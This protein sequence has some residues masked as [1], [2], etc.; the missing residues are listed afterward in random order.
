MTTVFRYAVAI[1][2]LVCSSTA[3]AAPKKGD[4]EAAKAHYTIGNRHYARGE[5]DLAIAEF[6]IAYD[7]SEAP[8]LLY[9]LGQAHRLN[10]DCAEAASYYRQFLA[11]ATEAA[12]AT[13]KNAEAFLHQLGTCAQERTPAGGEPA[14]GAVTPPIAG[15][16][17]PGD[18][19]GGT[20]EVDDT[21][22]NWRIAGVVL[23]GVGVA[24]A[25]VGVY[26][27]ART[28]SLS[29]DAVS[30]CGADCTLEENP[31]YG[32]YE[33][34]RTGAW[35]FSTLGAVAIAGGVATYLLAPDGQSPDRAVA[36]VPVRG[37]GMVS[38]AGTF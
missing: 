14:G 31:A 37:G 11:S 33:D 17:Q 4:R 16:V 34:A 29:D 28:Y 35:I 7:L 9:N 13:R 23:A 15:P 24:S 20:T 8:G 26:Y 10:G 21:G 6:E 22:R 25:G 5:Y 38:F 32:E 19:S 3:G 18:G 2:V 27:I 30:Q 36:A 12:A 1:A